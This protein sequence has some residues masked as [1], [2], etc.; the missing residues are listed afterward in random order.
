MRQNWTTNDI[1][2]LSVKVA[3][4]TGAN[5]GLGLEI[6]TQLAAKNAHV[7]LACR[8]PSKAEAA[9]SAILQVHPSATV[10][11]SKVDVS[12][13][14]SV[15]AFADEFLASNFRLDILMCNAGVMAFQERRESV[16]GH[17]LQFATNH[18]GHFL[19]TGLLHPLL[20]ATEGSRLVTHSSIASFSGKFNFD[21]LDAVKSYSPWDQYSMTK[22]ANIAFVHEYNRRVGEGPK[23]VTA[24][25][26]VVVGQLQEIQAGDSKFYKALYSVFGWF[27]GTYQT[28]ALPAIY[29]CTEPSALP[30]EFYGPKSWFGGIFAWNGKFPALV[31]PS[32]IGVDPEQTRKLWEISEEMTGFKFDL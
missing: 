2:D 11:V 21:D 25:P 9:K 27:S 17:E 16:D 10:T 3:V 6:A 14:A 5:I 30:G 29:G 28:G 18:L 4:V 7:Y 32:K 8:T 26:G 13:F 31:K 22:L 19:L 23:G 12:S 1:P 24:H 15:R 20:K